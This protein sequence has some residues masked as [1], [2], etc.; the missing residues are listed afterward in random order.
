VPPDGG[1]AQS[2]REIGKIFIRRV[3][4]CHYLPSGHS[5]SVYHN[6]GSFDASG[7]DM[8]LLALHQYHLDRVLTTALCAARLFS[9]C[10]IN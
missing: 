8:I 10:K 3:C 5:A 1:N 7:N 2:L 9:V 4:S 6:F